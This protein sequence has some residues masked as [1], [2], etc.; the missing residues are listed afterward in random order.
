MAVLKA[1]EK[2][3]QQEVAKLPRCAR[4][5]KG[6]LFRPCLPLL[7]PLAR[8]SGNFFGE[9]ALLKREKRGATVRATSD[10]VQCLRLHRED[11]DKL[12]GSLESLTQEMEARE[13]EAGAA[14]AEQ[15]VRAVWARGWAGG[16]V[17]GGTLAH[18]APTRT[19]TRPHQPVDAVDKLDKSI[20][21]EDLEQLATL[22]TGTFG[23]V[24]L[25]RHKPTQRV[26]AL[27]SMYKA[28]IVAT[29]QQVRAHTGPLI[30]PTPRLPVGHS[31]RTL[32]A[33]PCCPPLLS[34]SP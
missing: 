33:A 7:T 29:H 20:K 11:F 34:C 23:R 32:T 28:H 26:M 6:C 22:G 21:F 16:A 9:R 1:G 2:A 14:V 30:P 15:A 10:E 12:L 4:S 18:C 19:Y 24:R 3:E 17:G 8:P 5:P 13:R 27:K 31:L 25:V